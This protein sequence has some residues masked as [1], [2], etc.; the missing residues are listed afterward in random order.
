MLEDAGDI[1]PPHVHHARVSAAA[2]LHHLGAGDFIWQAFDPSVKADLFSTGLAT[3]GGIYLVDP[4]PLS[5][6]AL[7]AAVGDA[8][9]AGVIVTNANHARAA[10]EVS[11]ELGG[12]VCAHPQAK[13]DAEHV[14]I[15]TGA[16]SGQLPGLEVIEIPGAGEGE[17]TLYR[18]DRHGGTLVIGD[19]VINAG[20]DGFSLLPAKYCTDAKLLRKSVANLLDYE[21]QRIFFA[22][23][24][25]ILLSGRVRLAELLDDRR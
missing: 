8:R 12:V 2:D 10:A 22:H 6:Q 9:L 4:I 20:S 14:D 19:A 5:R 15:L 23:G 17:I 7:T 3:V 1:G 21:F 16:A 18:K 24:T 11:K 13:L 25:P